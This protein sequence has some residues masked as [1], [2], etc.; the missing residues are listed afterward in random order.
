VAQ[1]AA[2]TE[3]AHVRAYDVN[4][5][6]KRPDPIINRALGRGGLQGLQEVIPKLSDE[7]VLEKTWTTILIPRG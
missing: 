6:P 5:T 1:G 7:A 2:G 4:A 3:P